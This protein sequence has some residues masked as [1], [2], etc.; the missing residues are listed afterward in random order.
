M[1]WKKRLS[2]I[3]V[4]VF[5]LSWVNVPSGQACIN[6]SYSVIYDGNGH[7]DGVPPIDQN[8]YNEGDIVVVA[9]KGSLEKDFHTF[10]GWNDEP[11]GSG[12]YYEG[13]FCM[14]GKNLTLY[15]QWCENEKYN[16][17]Y[18][19]NGNTSGNEPVDGSSPYYEGEEV[20]VLG[21]GNLAK[22]NYTFSGWNTQADGLG[23]NYSPGQVFSMPGYYVCLYAQ[24]I[25]NDKFSV[26]YYGNENTGGTAPI[27]G[28][29]PYYSGSEV[30]VLG[31]GDLIREHHEFSYWNTSDDGSG[32]SY[33]MGDTFIIDDNV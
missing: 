28:S 24:W 16:V 32:V 18:Y 19:G 11:D 21:N 22:A 6:P 15:A 4:F 25:E 1:N 27:D 12:D 29:S 7:T 3:M 31:E 20:S 33:S 9:G 26:L 8:Q 17:T 2:A 5:M 13:T 30:Y 23:I 14:P 10:A